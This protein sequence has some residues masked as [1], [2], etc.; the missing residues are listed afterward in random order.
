LL[1]AFCS[2]VDDSPD[3][4]ALLEGASGSPKRIGEVRHGLR[5]VILTP[6][7]IIGGLLPSGLYEMAAALDCSAGHVANVALQGIPIFATN[8]L[9]PVPVAVLLSN[10]HGQPLSIV[11]E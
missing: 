9:V 8:I 2:A 4:G 6:I 1:E 7:S 3:I 5:H 10:A 11:R